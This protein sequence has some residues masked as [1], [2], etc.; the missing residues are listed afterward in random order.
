[1]NHTKEAATPSHDD[2]RVMGDL[3]VIHAQ[4]MKRAQI[5]TLARTCLNFAKD[6]REVRGRNDQD[7]SN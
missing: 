1:M 2:V 4:G 6:L 7:I 5:R 3:I